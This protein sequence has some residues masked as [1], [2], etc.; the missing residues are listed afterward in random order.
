MKVAFVVQRYGLDIS[1]GAEQHCRMLAERLAKRADIGEVAVFTTCADSYVTWKNHYPSGATEIN[2]VRVERFRTVFPRAEPIRDLIGLVTRRWPA[3]RLDRWWLIAQGPYVPG[4]IARLRA[5]RRNYDA[6]VFFT[7]LYYPTVYGLPEVRERALLIPTA[8]DEPAIYREVF[9]PLFRMPRAIAFNT[10]EE[11]EFVVKRFGELGVANEIVG[12]G[13]DL[14]DASAQVSD[15]WPC[16]QPY[17]LYLGRLDAAKGVTSL[18]D[19]FIRF[20]H[21]HRDERLEKGDGDYPVSELRLVLAGRNDGLAVPGREDI[22]TAGFVAGERK[23]R[24]LEGCEALVLPS[25]HESLSLVLLEAWTARKGVLVNALCNVT[26]GLARRAQGGLAYSNPADFGRQLFD[27]L[28]DSK[29]RRRLADNG[30]QFV[31]QNY[32][33]DAVEER[34]MRLIRGVSEQGKP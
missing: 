34:L 29:R 12:C 16:T 32:T 26:S 31:E 23:R 33:W 9:E 18:I 25:R 19:D 22:M 27:L 1:G 8:H 17:V 28:R 21:D 15:G 7:Y 4:L 5:L 10:H 20:K 14:V 2:G 13:V 30:M 6:F 3:M 11:R 24:L